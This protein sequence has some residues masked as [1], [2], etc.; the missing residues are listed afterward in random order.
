MVQTQVQTEIDKIKKLL[1]GRYKPQRI[2]LFGSFAWG[3]P[4]KD[5]DLDFLII[6]QVDK[7]RPQREAVIYK[8]LVRYFKNRQ[9]PVDIIVHTP[10]ETKERLSLG[11]PFIKEVL[12]RGKVIYERS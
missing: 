8:L 5:S 12:T 6:K 7:P 3:K 2:I 1:V 10:Q 11:D 4:H 9:M